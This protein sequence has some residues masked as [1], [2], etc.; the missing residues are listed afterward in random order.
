MKKFLVVVSL[1]LVLTGYAN[2]GSSV[3][4]YVSPTGAGGKNGTDWANAYDNTQLQTAINESGITEVWVAAGT[5]YPTADGDRTISFNMKNDVAIYGGFAGTET[6]LEERNWTSNITI[7]S[8]DIGTTGDNSD[9]SYHVVL[10][11]NLNSTAILDG[12]TIQKANANNNTYGGGIINSSSSPTLANLI[13]SDN[14]AF[15]G[16]GIYNLSSSP[17]MINIAISR[18]SAE[19]NGGGVYYDSSS[20]TMTNCLINSNSAL[21]GGGLFFG[22]ASSPIMT[23]C[24]IAENLAR[25]NVG[26]IYNTLASNPTLNNSIIWGNAPTTG[27][28]QVLVGDGVM[29]LNYSCYP[30]GYGDV[31]IGTGTFTPDANCIITNPKFL[32]PNGDFRLAGNSP[33]ADAGSDAL[34]SETTDIRGPGFG[35]NLLKNDAA[36]IGSIDMGAYEFKKGADS[37]VPNVLRIYV[38]YSATG[39]NNGSSWANAFTTLKD[40][41]TAAGRYYEIW[42]A[43]GTY[44][45]TTG[46][47]RTISFNMKNEV[48]IYG[49]FAGTETLLSQRNSAINVTILSGDIGTVSD[50]SDNTYHIVANSGINRSAIL[51]GFTIKNG[52][53][54]DGS[55]GG[56][57]YN[58]NSSPTLSNLIV[59]GNQ[60]GNYGGGIYNKSSSPLMAN[61]KISG[62]TSDINGGGL[63]NDSSSPELNNCLINGNSADLGGGFF[64]GAASSAILNNCTIAENSARNKGGGIYNQSS[65]FFNNSIIW[66]NIATSS[67]K[68]VYASAGM[69]GL[70][71]SCYANGEGDVFKDYGSFTPDVNCI[72]QNPIF[73][74]PNS[75]FRLVGNSP[76]SDTGSD[77]LNSETTDIRGAGFGRNLLKTDAESTGT[78]DMGAYEFKKGTD[79]EE[80]NLLRI[81]VNSS[82]TGLNNGT[83][84][85][86]AYT[87]LKNAITA[88]GKYYEIWV[89]AGT[90]KPTTGTDRTISFNMKNDLAIYGGFAGTETLLSD[91]NWTTNVTILSGDIGTTSD[92]SDNSYHVVSNTDLNSTAILD[93]FSIQG[94]NSPDYGGGI[95]NSGSPSSSGPLTYI[96]GSSPM[97]VN[98][99]ISGNTA[100]LGGGGMYNGSSSP[101]LTNCTISGNSTA[102]NGGGIFNNPVYCNLHFPGT[103]WE[104]G[105]RLINCLI[106]NNSAAGNGGG[107]YNEGVNVPSVSAAEWNCYGSSKSGY[108]MTNCTISKNS[109]NKGGG[110]YNSYFSGLSVNNSI[111]WG[112]ITS[113]LSG[114][115]IYFEEGLISLFYSCYAS[116]SVDFYSGVAFS[117]ENCIDSNPKFVNPNSDFRIAGNSPCAD[118]GFYGYNNETTDIRG[119]GF[120]RK[121]LKT[122]SGTAGT[123]DM[124]AYEFKK[125]TDPEVPDVLRL[126]VKWDASGS[127]NGSSWANAFT[128]LKNAIAA[129]SSPYEIWVAKGTYY[130]TTGTDRTISFNMKEGVNIYGGFA[131]TETSLS[132]R[133]ISTN[134]TI[135]SGDIGTKGDNSDNSYQVVLY[136]RINNNTILDGFTIEGGS[137]YAGSGGGV[138]II[139]SSPTL[140]NC[141]IRKNSVSGQGGGIFNQ[142]SSP[143][144]INCLVTENDGVG[145]RITE[146]S[147]PTIT[148]CTITNNSLGIG[149]Y[150]GTTIVINSI[151]WGNGSS[152]SNGSGTLTLANTCYANG[153]GDVNNFGT[154]NT[155]NFCI[156]TNPKF[157]NPNNDF[158][159]AGNSPC[160]DVPLDAGNNEATD[161]RGLGFGR[162]LLKTDAGSAGKID[163][164]AYEF[165]KGTDPDAPEIFRIY[166]NASATGLK[167]GTSWTNAYTS[168]PSAIAAATKH[169]EIWVAAGTYKPTTETDRTISFNMKDGVSIYGG[170][171]GTE[172]SLSERNLTANETILSG[173]I[174]TSGVNT[175]N[176]YHVVYSTGLTYT[177]ILDGFT[178]QDG[179]SDTDGGGVYNLSSSPTISN[180]KIVG[181]VADRCGGGLYNQSSSA[182][183]VDCIISGNTTY[184]GFY[185]G[186][187]V[188]NMSFG[189]P[190]LTNCTISG[191]S[192]V[193]YGGGVSNYG[194]VPTMTNCLIINNTSNSSTGGVFNSDS[195]SATVTN[196]TISGNSKEGV[197]SFNAGSITFNNSIVWGN[198]G[199]EIVTGNDITATLNYSCYDGGDVNFAGSFTPTNCITTYPIFVNPNSDFRIAGNSPCADTGNDAV[200]SETTDIRGS[201]FGRKL[202][203]TNASTTGTIDM[204]AYE[205]KNGTD[206]DEPDVL[207]IYVNASAKGANNGTSWA[208]AY[209]SLETAIAADVDT[210][211]IRVAGGTYKPTIQIGG[212]GPRYAAFKMKYG[213]QISGGYNADLGVQVDYSRGGANETILSGDIGI[214]GDAS[215][216]CYHVVHNPETLGLNTTVN[217]KL[218]MAGT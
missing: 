18:N 64:N 90:Y 34:N 129:A 26:G 41:I 203:K 79:P 123:I 13:V 146:S 78:I 183:I 68:Q 52:N 137:A 139:S 125:G 82:A 10:N 21:F 158:R 5:Y 89:A 81:Y 30:N 102:G 6:A 20:P 117:P 51:D 200:N 65:I 103:P 185:G 60:A 85:A 63:Y 32:D 154:F 214:V 36:T 114:N 145:I 80:P 22:N 17:M 124:G 215:D 112:N 211:E 153:T 177:A 216:N 45:P 110:V 205:F 88:A 2:G 140:T 48:A 87:S 135:L 95:L 50:N 132:Q 178:I 94:G 107:I 131:G 109:A 128:S 201:G 71:Y 160:T 72:T 119:T 12:F 27:G 156:T 44:Y 171:A 111:I 122:D 159:I 212:I 189:S 118:I 208:N 42:V 161:I 31:L 55:N 217:G 76:C 4:R 206:P 218:T 147:S 187:G 74:D 9:N 202:L 142:S 181:N 116:N 149:N 100:I 33:C 194:C 170:F 99:I 199:N 134:E 155:T 16:G 133:S 47:D 210:L 62:N 169:F 115:Q 180:C 182:T 67:G 130:P 143:Q 15:Q 207:R 40:A 66:E 167:N 164:G 141:I 91:R 198:G 186:G 163:M 92:N 38:N 46:S 204:G 172:T 179:H 61:I 127:G 151:I 49:G 144:I 7:L 173:D 77:A 104:E 195:A 29:T 190:R 136:W 83:N 24:T 120:D 98:L 56:G 197:Y 53:A 35:R 168:L 37:E 54:N 43:S 209:T 192:S 25:S 191:N 84:W 28:A 175:D 184:G 58:S 97:L 69:I 73:V 138:S 213:V 1:M 152:I 39:S 86:N 108:V 165:K 101:A 75:D 148:N 113:T 174:G 96:I 105:V 3:V 162:K 11:T 106:A 8:G 157:I 23:N 57:V 193:G 150:Q 59:T 70:S 93:G 166:V 188:M 196:C 19:Y 176:S 121:L 14:Y 126:Y